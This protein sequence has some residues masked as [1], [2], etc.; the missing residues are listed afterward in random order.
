[1]N[2]KFGDEIASLVKQVSKLSGIKYRNVEKRQAENFM[3]MFLSISKDL[4]VIIIK[5]SDRLHNMK[6]LNF[7]PKDKQ[8]RIF[9]ETLEL[10][11][12]ISS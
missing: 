6:T 7:L 10:Y 9:L 4:R 3:Q 2:S 5:F 1:M 11:C 8:K 12:T